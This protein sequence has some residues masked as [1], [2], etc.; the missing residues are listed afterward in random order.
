MEA[1]QQWLDEICP[2]LPKDFNER[3]YQATPADRQVPLPTPNVP[4]TLP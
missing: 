2:F 4:V 3:Y 1:I